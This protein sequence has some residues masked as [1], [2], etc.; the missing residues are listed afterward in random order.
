MLSYLIAQLMDVL[1]LVMTLPVA[2]T[3]LALC[4]LVI[5]STLAGDWGKQAGLYGCVSARKT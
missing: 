1:V 3:S 4:P 2:G 5:T